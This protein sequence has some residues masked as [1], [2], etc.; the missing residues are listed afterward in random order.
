VDYIAGIDKKFIA[1][2]AEVVSLWRQGETPGPL[3][4][5][6]YPTNKCNL[7]CKHCWQRTNEY[8]KTYQSELSDERMMALLDEGHAMGAKYWVIKGG[9]EPMA[10]GKLVMKMCA[11]IRELGMNGILHTNG[12]LFKESQIEALTEMGWS[13]LVFSL[14]APNAETNDYL[15]TGGFEKAAAALQSFKRHRERL[16]VVNPEIHM[17]TVVTRTSYRILDEMVD[18]VHDSGCTYLNCNGLI[19][20]TESGDEFVL[21]EEDRAAL[22][23]H[24]NKAIQRAA[25]LGVNTNL[26][27]FLDEM[28]TGDPNAMAPGKSSSTAGDYTAALCYAPFSEF[29]IQ[30]DGNIAPCCMADLE[31]STVKESTLQEAWLGPYMTDMR[32]SFLDNRPMS[33]CA[34]CPASNFTMIEEIRDGLNAIVRRDESNAAQEAVRLTASALSSLKTRG[35]SGTAKRLREWVT[36]KMR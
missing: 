4:I 33:Y 16:G 27:D 13:E 23:E 14:D 7:Q 11:R 31:S 21:R 22:P 18:F 36:I 32:E 5:T 35:I 1:E 19:E 15:R 12:S 34:R 2:S 17:S 9:G 3:Q 26:K 24:V 10:R 29:V 25:A 28:V 8:D 6:L 20:H 30:A